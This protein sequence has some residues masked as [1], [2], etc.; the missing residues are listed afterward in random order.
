M[1]L[2]VLQGVVIGDPRIAKLP[3]GDTALTF[4]VQTKIDGRSRPSVPVEWTGPASQLPKVTVD[5][6]VAVVGSVARRFYRSGGSI[7]TRVYVSPIKI[8]V[9]QRK[10]QAAAIAKALGEALS[11]TNEAIA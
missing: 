1:N 2:C 5:A 7:Q 3:S 10:R 8:V 4:D 9:K 6:P 11:A